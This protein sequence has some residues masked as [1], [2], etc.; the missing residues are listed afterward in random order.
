M[1]PGNDRSG[2]AGGSGDNRSERNAEP[3]YQCETDRELAEQRFEE[4]GCPTCVFL[5]GGASA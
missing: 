1:R 2:E 5:P 3:Q 4:D